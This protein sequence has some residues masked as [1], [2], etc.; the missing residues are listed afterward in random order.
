[1]QTD[2]ATII[3]IASWLIF[4]GFGGLLSISLKHNKFR[5]LNGILGNTTLKL[6]QVNS[7]YPMH[8]LENISQF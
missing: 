7:S 8:L 5:L 6:K 4:I 3:V 1:M 2:L